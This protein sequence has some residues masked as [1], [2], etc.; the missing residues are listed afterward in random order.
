MRFGWSANDTS[1][2]LRGTAKIGAVLFI[3][4]YALVYIREPFSDLGDV[5]IINLL[6]VIAAA[7]AAGIATMIWMRYEPAEPARRIWR[8]FAMGLWLWASAELIYGYMDIAQA[9]VTVGMPD[10]FWVSAYIFFAYALFLQ[11]HLLAQPTKQELGKQGALAVAA[12]LVLYF[13]LYRVL[14]TWVHPGSWVEAAVNTFYPVA[15]LFLA[16]IA[17]WLIRHFRG[18][19]FARPWVGLLAFSFTDLLYAFIDT[20]GLYDQANS[21][22]T[23]LFDT[24]YVAAYLVL[25]LGLLSLWAFLK[26]GLRSPG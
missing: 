9:E 26:Y 22:W 3:A 24:T 11:Y 25:G 18:G 1:A 20:S 5:L 6:L 23:A 21:S 8:S 15:D 19:V 4:V 12:L 10:L 17:V 7:L 14:V 2:R 16:L 13:V